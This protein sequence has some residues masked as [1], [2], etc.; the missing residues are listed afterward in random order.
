MAFQDEHTPLLTNSDTGA[1]AGHDN[2]VSD[3]ES[4][5]TEH[6]VDNNESIDTLLARFGS[7]VETPGL[8]GGVLGAPLV[9]GR[10]RHPTVGMRYNGSHSSLCRSV[11]SIGP[12]SLSP[13]I[14][15]TGGR[16]KRSALVD[17][18]NR[19]EVRSGKKS[20]FI[21]GVNDWQF[22]TIFSGILLVIF[23]SDL[24]CASI[25]GALISADFVL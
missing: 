3:S 19:E 8:G 2:D 13:A 11:D 5:Y 25:Y 7:P 22:W 14:S 16:S 9:K 10:V 12:R 15:H 24:V 23:V 6:S 17:N 1:N 18:D 20:K 21:G 4:Q